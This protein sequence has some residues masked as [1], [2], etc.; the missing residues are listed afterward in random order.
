MTRQQASDTEKIAS[1]NDRQLEMIN[2]VLKINEN[3]YENLPM[4]FKHAKDIQEGKEISQTELKIMLAKVNFFILHCAL[5]S[6]PYYPTSLEKIEVSE[7]SEILAI[8]EDI[9]HI[10]FQAINSS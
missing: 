4:L 10:F 2:N 5:L 8:L 7:I 1:E 6:A 9:Q 3:I